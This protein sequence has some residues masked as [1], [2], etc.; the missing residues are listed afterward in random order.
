[1]GLH[2]A[3]E[4][5]E[6]SIYGFTCRGVFA[7]ARILSGERVWWLVA[8]EEMSS[9][10]MTRAQILAHPMSNTLQTYSYQVG[11]DEY[12]STLN[13]EQ[14]PSWFFNH[15]CDPNCGYVSADLIVALR[16][17][18]PGEQVA[19][20]YAFTETEASFHAGMQCGC[21]ATLCKGKL[22]FGDY[23][24]PAFVRK[25]RHCLSPHIKARADERSWFD[26]RVYPCK[27][28]LH[29]EEF[30]IGA[31]GPIQRGEVVLVFAGKI[32]L[33][34]Y[35]IDLRQCDERAQEL[36]LQV[37]DH[38]YQVPIGAYR[39]MTA[40][41]DHGVEVPDLINH[42]C[43][44][45]CGQL[46]SVTLVAMRD[47]AAGEQ[48]TF[49]YAM[50]S[51]APG[52]VVDAFNCLC[53]AKTCRGRVQPGDWMRSEIQDRYWP[54]FAPHMKSRIL[55]MRPELAKKIDIPL[56]VKHVNGVHELNGHVNGHVN[57]HSNGNGMEVNGHH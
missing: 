36:S 8:G 49:D 56:N 53:G 43:D 17:I 55:A 18:E 46:D 3:I 12:Q 15:T 22:T 20:D 4:V 52:L 32:I 39:N 7:R 19:Y 48:L 30:G 23:R 29:K 5:K 16:D 2:E 45:N 31:L 10:T 50:S 24:S 28:D 14:D 1:M 47:I 34:K 35:A 27:V 25:W 42:S 33:D 38:L 41:D 44:A 21:G 37:H 26:P 9:V 13:P 40:N 54:Y 6:F 11:M 51:T 57:G